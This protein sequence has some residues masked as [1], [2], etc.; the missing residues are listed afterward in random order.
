MNGK[1]TQY[2]GKWV[3][4]QRDERKQITRQKLRDTFSGNIQVE[5]IPAIYDIVSDEPKILRVAAYCRVSTDQ[6]SQTSSYELQVQH[7]QQYIKNMPEWEYVDTY[8]DE[9][10]SGTNVE[11]RERFKEMIEDCKA[12]KIDLIITKDIRR[13]ARNTLD[14]L[15][16]VRLL[17]NLD[18]PVGILFE[19]EH[20]NTLD[21]NTDA[22]LALLSSVAQ[23][24]SENKSEAIKWSYKRRF[25]NGIP[26]CPTWA[27]L[28][29]TTDD[30][31]NMV[32]V[33]TEA[34]I[35]RYI[36]ASYLEGWS[37]IEIAEKL[38]NAG[39]PTVKG[40]SVWAPAVVY[41][42]LRNEKYCGDVICQKTFTPDF[43]SH[44]SVK[45]RGQERKYKLTDHHEAII[46]R[47][48]W[49]KVQEMLSHRGRR[50]MGKRNEKTLQRVEMTVI[51]RGRFKGFVILNPN[52]GKNDLQHIYQK[53]GITPKY[54]QEESY[55]E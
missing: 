45:N 10:R 19:D 27:L 42:M 55:A 12:G 40:N 8:A 44:K 1:Q 48:A 28:G 3:R 43:L 46:E 53:L 15:S 23:G 29:Y 54:N 33:P 11:K 9:G 5:V 6:E 17:K 37:T 4:S 13:F 7:Y 51:K 50:P 52:W 35:I 20:L 30:F 26:M 41:S 25:A 24:E 22:I 31:G 39:I 18:P 14:C 21:R 38:T 2:K 34:E 16:Y 36:Y 47:S 32:I 49:E